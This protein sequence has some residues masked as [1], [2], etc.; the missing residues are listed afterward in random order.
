M[1]LVIDPTEVRRSELA[2]FLRSR[3]ERLAPAD[4]GLSPGS[5]RR[6][7]GLRREEVALLAGVGATWYTW[8]EQGRDIRPSAEALKALARALKL[9]QTETRHLF[10]LGQR[11]LP[12]AVTPSPEVV[13]AVLRRMLDRM[14]DQP[15]Y[16]IGRR[17]D[18]LAWNGAAAA[19]FGDYGRLQGEERN[20]LHLVFTSEAHRH[21]LVDWPEVARVAL[22]MFRLD[23]ARHSG[24]TGFER[25]IGTLNARSSEFRDWW[26]KHEV[27][28]PL[29]GAKRVRHP[30]V[31]PM[32]FDYTMLAVVGQ[33]DLRLVVY[34]ALEA[35]DSLTKLSQLLHEQA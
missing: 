25:L 27:V 13:P 3:R 5:R 22:A 30:Q 26:P 14:S 11:L 18:V 24:E 16:V 10:V 1:S 2:G 9:D 28:V 6:T 35:D 32:S 29:A 20:I 15:A 34:T 12:E 4:V 7:P 31:G 21:L 23:H 8:L 17:W 19:V 33:S